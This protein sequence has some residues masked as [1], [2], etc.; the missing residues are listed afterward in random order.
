MISKWRAALERKHGRNVAHKVLRTW[1]ALWK[2]MLAMKIARSPDP[3]MG[4]RNRAP[5]PRWQG[6]LSIAAASAGPRLPF[7][8]NAL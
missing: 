5:A 6:F 1:R 2:V 8:S 3:S 7:L 4:V